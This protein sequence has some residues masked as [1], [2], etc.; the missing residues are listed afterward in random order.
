MSGGSLRSALTKRS[1]S[2]SERAGSTAVMPQTVADGGVGGRAA[3]LAEDASVAGE[4]DDIVYGQKIG[5]EAE[6]LDQLQLVFDLRA[7]LAGQTLG[8]ALGGA[9]PGE[10]NQLLLRRAAFRDR[11][12]RIFVAQFVKTEPASVGDLQRA[13]DRIRIPREQ[14]RHLLR[15]LQV[16]LGVGIEAESRLADCA[17]FAD[18]GQNVLQRPARRGCAHGY[19]WSPP[20][21]RG[22]GR[23][24]PPAP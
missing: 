16:A 6:L 13:A 12:D 18:A 10:T 19:H 23:Q 5:G 2:R 20:A 17:V 14:P 15:R 3:S 8:I 21:G 4:A 1:N 7:H 24:V 9:L 22:R 11:I